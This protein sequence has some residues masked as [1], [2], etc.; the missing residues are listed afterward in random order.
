MTE[1]EEKHRKIV[2]FDF[3]ADEMLVVMLSD[4]VYYLVDP[5]GKGKESKQVQLDSS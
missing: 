5:M 1:H 3:I 4:G 2:G